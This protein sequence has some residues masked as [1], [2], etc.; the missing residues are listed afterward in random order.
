VLL[1]TIRTA[2]TTDRITT[3]TI[4]TE[5]LDRMIATAVREYSRYAPIIDSTFITTVADQTEYNLEALNCLWVLSCLWWPVGQLFAELHAGAEQVYILNKPSRYH[6]PSER[7]IDNINQSAHIH[8]MQ[9]FWE[10]RNQTLVISPAP[11]TAA[12]DNLEIT[13]AAL[14][15]LNADETGYDTIPDEDLD[16]LADL[17]TA[18]YLQARMSE[19][20]LEADYAEGL[21]KLTVHY[22]PGNLRETIKVLRQ[23]VKEKYGGTGVAI[24]R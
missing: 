20:A 23:G 16:I 14:H 4:A 10:Q 11:T 24:A 15:V 17:A 5:R 22:V 3:E 21:Q 13:Y 18:N 1:T 2:I 7:I 12:T 8:A 19:I 6:M 9:G